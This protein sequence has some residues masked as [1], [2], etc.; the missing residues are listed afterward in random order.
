M[1][2]MNI[3][4]IIDTY[5]VIYVKLIYLKFFF[6]KWKII[7]SFEVKFQRS[8]IYNMKGVF[9]LGLGVNKKSIRQT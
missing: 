6:C 3:K 1:K 8:P 2:I 7:N 9:Y 5:T 4:M